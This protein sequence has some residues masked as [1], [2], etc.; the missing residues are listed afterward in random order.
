MNIYL[1]LEYSTDYS[2]K[3]L[4]GSMISE[5]ID[6]IGIGLAVD[7]ESLPTYSKVIVNEKEY[8][9][10]SISRFTGKIALEGENGWTSSHVLNSIEESNFQIVK[11]VKPLNFRKVFKD[12][13]KAVDNM[14]KCSMPPPYSLKRRHFKRYFRSVEGLSLVIKGLASYLAEHHSGDKFTLVLPVNYTLSGEVYRKVDEL[15]KMLKEALV[16]RG[17]KNAKVEV[18]YFT[19]K[20][21]TWT[22]FGDSMLNHR[23][24]I[25]RDEYLIHKSLNK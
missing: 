22:A 24:K 4:F 20:S 15:A 12:N 13:A 21:P 3:T 6:I 10:L 23:L 9:V 2:V 16:N 14:Y 18:E 11:S 19:P 7:K 25:I 1:G 5:T 17:R 8:K